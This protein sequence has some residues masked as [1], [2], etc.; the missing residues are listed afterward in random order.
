[1]ANTHWNLGF[2]HDD[3]LRRYHDLL[4]SKP[5]V[6]GVE[7]SQTQ[8]SFHSNHYADG[9]PST[10]LL[11]LPQPNNH[12]STQTFPRALDRNYNHGWFSDI[13]TIPEWRY[14]PLLYCFVCYLLSIDDRYFS[15][16]IYRLVARDKHVLL[17]NV[18]LTSI[19]RN[20][21][22]YLHKTA[23]EHRVS[24]IHRWKLKH[25]NGLNTWVVTWVLQDQA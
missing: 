1:M 15:L 7:P 14:L 24:Y 21:K 19:G 10:N 3:P 9:P 22:P 12:P 25:S 20:D 11:L 23:R 16:D 2:M 4:L 8:I 13:A 6:H 5:R 18:H 17:Y